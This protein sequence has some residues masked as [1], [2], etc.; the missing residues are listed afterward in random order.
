MT[1]S[2][3]VSVTAALA[4]GLAWAQP[5][6]E[7]SGLHAGDLAR[8]AIERNRDFLAVKQRVAQA[9]G[10]LR[11]AGVRPSPTVEIEESTGRPLGTRGE[12]EFSA[13]Y[14]HTFETFGKRGKRIGLARRGV[15]L[16][17]AEVADRVRQLSY[18]IKIRYAEAV[19]EQ[20]KLEAIR[21][22]LEVN[23]QSYRV[24]EVRVEQG[25]AAPLERQLLLADLSRAEAQQ[26]VFSGRAE[27]ALLE[28]KRAAGLAPSEPLALATEPE[29]AV[30][31]LSL[32]RLQ[33]LALES[34]P[35]LRTLGLLEQQALAEVEL[36]Q[37][38]SRP[39]LTASVRYSR[40]NSSFDQLGF[41]R[42]G[43]LTPLRDRDN[44]LTFG[45]SVPLFRSRRNQG[46]LEAA[47]ARVAA[48][49][50][51]R[52]HLETSIRG[53]VEGAFRRRTAGQRALDILTRGVL[54]QSEQNLA[55]IREAY[56]LG[57]L[58]IL[59]VLNEQRRLIETQLAGI[60]AESEL[61]QS[62]AELERAVGGTVR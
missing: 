14:F 36:S 22:L 58:R 49:R 6:A 16:A 26:A 55:V 43:Q 42:A 4:S 8:I 48:A 25:D 33:E 19:A 53:E 56:S 35:D 18:E 31:D 30:H 52:E 59:D 32:F 3:V 34:R 37:A 28:L 40:R 11:Q 23:R 45:L 41:N 13:G 62:I 47:L 1:W 20:R 38:E 15:D 61:F 50:L 57:Q 29:G 12:E 5:Q 60:D 39:D 17:E 54:R 24:T 46:A 7:S 9:Q 2:Q 10:L 51:R 21:R 27:R 44:V